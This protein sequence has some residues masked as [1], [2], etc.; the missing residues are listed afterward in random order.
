MKQ[1]LQLIIL[2]L[3]LLLLTSCYD[4]IEL[5]QQSNVIAIGIDKEDEKGSF[6]FTFQIANPEAGST[7]STIGSKEEEKETITVPGTDILTATSLA[8]SFVTKRMVLDHTKV[9]VVSKE[10][11]ESNDFLRIIQSA[12]RKPEIRGDVQIIVCKEEAS[13]FLRNNQPSM[14]R[15][16]HKYYQFML[17]RAIQTGLIPDA[18]FHRFFQITEGDADLFLAIYATTLEENEK[19][20]RITK[21]HNYIAGQIPKE[22]G[23]RTQFIGSAVFKKGKMID[24][25]SG[26]E[27][28]TSNIL[29][30]T[31][32]MDNIQ[33]TYSDPIKPD[34]QVAVD[35]IQKVN[36]IIDIQYNKETN[37]ASIDVT[38]PF[39]VRIIA[40]PSMVN[41]LSNKEH[42]KKLCNTIEQTNEN[43]ANK[44]IE[45]SQKIYKSDPFYWSLYIRKKFKD[46]PSFE[47]AN[48]DEEIYPNADINVSFQLKRMSF[49]KMFNDSR[50]N[51]VTE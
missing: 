15:R 2:L 24:I 27:T 33:V 51:E 9:V 31:L 43:I 42:Q 14:E 49:G 5:E 38:V 30:K 46:I 44:L 17:Q 13:Q 45:K 16:P 39:E 32:H 18:D 48:W 25:L 7:L 1:L 22:G 10:L 36:P 6:S 4:K 23:N 3:S 8:N 37:H 50:L 40:I 41:Y 26:Q 47:K 28:R 11:A 12:S 19:E 20:Y 34:Y 29:D 21:E 35:Y